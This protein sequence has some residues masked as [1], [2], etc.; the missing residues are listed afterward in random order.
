MIS[1]E[2]RSKQGLGGDGGFLE[3]REMGAKAFSKHGKII[4][5][6]GEGKRQSKAN[7]GVLVRGN[8]K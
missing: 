7:Q 5:G 2:C 3:L 8:L 4:G 6:K 1:G